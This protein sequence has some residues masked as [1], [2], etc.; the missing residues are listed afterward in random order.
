MMET[1]G[2]GVWLGQRLNSTLFRVGG[3]IWV[4][5]ICNADTEI[6]QVCFGIA[7]ENI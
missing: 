5:F 6:E 3:F 2:H 7:L 1:A 4:T